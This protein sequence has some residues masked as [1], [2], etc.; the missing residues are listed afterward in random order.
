[1][2]LH[3]EYLWWGEFISGTKAQLQALGI[4]PGVAFPGEDG[5]NR[6]QIT[7]TDPR[8]FRGELRRGTSRY[9]ELAEDGQAGQF[10]IRIKYAGFDLEEVWEDFSRG[11]RRSSCIWADEFVGA[12]GDLVA[13]GL[14][15]MDKLPGVHG[16]SRKRTLRISPL[17][18]VYEGAPTS[19]PTDEYRG[20]GAKRI[21]RLPSGK[22]KVCVNVAEELAT[23]RRAKFHE[24]QAQREEA[25]WRAM[26]PAPLV[27]R[28][29]LRL[30][31]SRPLD[32][33]CD[34]VHGPRSA[35]V[36]ASLRLCATI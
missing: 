1:M 13:A 21:E 16:M 20:P 17:G 7:V 26:R 2:S 30:A 10:H 32:D 8:G 19:S 36:R 14:V 4:G 29:H 35:T 23:Q 9:V 15:E 5:A 25:A 3:V 6:N 34:G 22:F 27:A 11:V 33:D 31:T 12:A 18:K 24:L 28:A